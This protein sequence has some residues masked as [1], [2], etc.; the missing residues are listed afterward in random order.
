MLLLDS[1]INFSELKD[2]DNYSSICDNTITNIY[3]FTE[4]EIEKILC[5]EIYKKFGIESPCCNI[6][7]DFKNMAIK[8]AEIYIYKNESFISE[9]K[10]ITFIKSKYDI[11][12]EV[13]I[14]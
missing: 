8:S 12:A 10:V 5:E 2:E 9:Y 7:I 14:Y 1:Q 4:D 6:I 3:R 13:F 11:D